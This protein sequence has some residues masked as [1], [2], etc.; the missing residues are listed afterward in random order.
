MKNLFI[1][2]GEKIQV[3][4]IIIFV[5]ELIGS[6]AGAIIFWCDKEVGIGFIIFICGPLFSLLSSWFLYGFGL[7]VENNEVSLEKESQTENKS[8]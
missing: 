2:V 4:A 3:L 5:L 7:I 8:N 6:L 1:N